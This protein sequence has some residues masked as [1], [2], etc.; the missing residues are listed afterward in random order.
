MQASIEL[1]QLHVVLEL[2]YAGFSAQVSPCYSILL[3]L[4]SSPVILINAPIIFDYVNW[5]ILIF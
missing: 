2:S 1:I 4:H 3:L 5:P